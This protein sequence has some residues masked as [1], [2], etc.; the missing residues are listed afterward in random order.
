MPHPKHEEKPAEQHADL[1]IEP[2]MPQGEVQPEQ[3][4]D[5]AGADTQHARPAA[6]I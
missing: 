1:P 2:E 6:P 3:A 4:E 5:V